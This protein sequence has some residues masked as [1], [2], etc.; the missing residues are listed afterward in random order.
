MKST[1][2]S[3]SFSRQRKKQKQNS[4]QSSGQRKPNNDALVIQ[5]EDT[6]NAI[7]KTVEFMFEGGMN[8]D[9]K[10]QKLT[11]VMHIPLYQC[12]R[13]G[14]FKVPL[15]ISQI[16]VIVHAHGRMNSYGSSWTH[17]EKI[18]VT[19]KMIGVK[20]SGTNEVIL[21]QIDLGLGIEL[22]GDDLE[23]VYTVSEIEGKWCEFT[24]YPHLNKKDK[25]STFFETRLDHWLSNAGGMLHFYSHQER[26]Y[27][28]DENL[29]ERYEDDSDY[30]EDKRLEAD[31]KLKVYTTISAHMPF[32]NGNLVPPP[33]GTNP[34]WE[35][36]KLLVVE[37]LEQPREWAERAVKNYI[38]FLELK[39][40]FNDCE[41]SF[42]F[43]PSK[44]ID[45]IWHT[46]LCFTER[47]QRDIMAFCGGTTLIEHTPV[48]GDAA[49]RRY[50]NAY[51][52]LKEKAEKK[53]NKE[54][55]PSWADEEFWP[56][57][58]KPEGFFYQ[59]SEYKNGD[60]SDDAISLE[61][62][63]QCG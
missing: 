25:P 7:L 35:A 47:Y 28:I 1:L 58:E 59:S 57:P 40:E 16:R 63:A 14:R 2:T 44:P 62:V 23:V 15:G 31:Y 19:G 55:F 36:L 52:T 39:K 21:S 37:R 18:D 5:E 60:D 46:H 33:V 20:R 30:D 48:L 12:K 56:D 51:Y 8:K 13:T 9:H 4:P 49:K 32:D 3:S 54:R 27:L 50:A 6:S 17:P 34:D 43:S 45:D 11:G 41:N 53:C 42:L 24:T 10:C 61:S 26:N 29:I 38:L 22:W